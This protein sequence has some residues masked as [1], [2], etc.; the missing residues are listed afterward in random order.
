LVKSSQISQT[1]KAKVFDL[2]GRLMK[3]FSFNSNETIV[4]GVDLKPGVYLVELRDGMKVK[5][6]RVVKY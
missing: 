1:I 5:T 2:Q 3:S 4:F 6:V